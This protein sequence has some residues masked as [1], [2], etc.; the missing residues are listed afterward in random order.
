ML[1][2]V[3]VHA[4]ASASARLVVLV[5]VLVLVLALLE[6]GSHWPLVTRCLAPAPGTLATHQGRQRRCLRMIKLVIMMT[7]KMMMKIGIF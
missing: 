2:L 4:S 3:L 6:S 5:L 1:V 7:E